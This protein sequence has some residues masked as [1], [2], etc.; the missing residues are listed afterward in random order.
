MKNDAGQT[1]RD[2]FLE[3][4]KDLA[5][6]SMKW[7]NATV[8][9]SMVVAALICTIGFSVVY[10]IPGGFDQA[11]GYP[12]FHHNGY[13]IAFVVLLAISFILSTTSIV[14][15]ISVFFSLSH[16]R[17]G[18]ILNRLLAGQILLFSSVFFLVMAFIHSFSI[19][20]LKG[21]A[22]YLEPLLYLLVAC[23]TIGC[24]FLFFMA[25]KSP[26][27]VK[28]RPKKHRLYRKRD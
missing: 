4:H 11:K 21:T 25:V 24:F 2:L 27:G 3:S 12:I 13:F 23:Y 5:S 16:T 22:Y 20:Y 18:A 14:F 9:V 15:F 6:E 8:N 10:Q 28:F 19:I 17:M 1:P 7:I 26:Y